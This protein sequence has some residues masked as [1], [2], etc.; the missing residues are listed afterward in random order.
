MQNK[1]SGLK[2]QGW[3]QAVYAISSTQKESLNV[4]RYLDDGRV[5]A[6]AQAGAG[7]LSAGLLTQ[8]AISSANALNQAL[9]ASQSAAI[10]DMSVTITFAG[11][12]TAD[13]YKDG[14]FFVNDATGEGHNYRIRGHAAGTADVVVYLYDPIRVALVASTSEWTCACNVQKLV[15]PCPV[16]L[17]GI[18]TGV[19]T[20]PVTAL[21]YFWNQVKGPCSV[22][23]NGTIVIGNEV[24]LHSTTIGSVGA[25]TTSDIIGS[26]GRVMLLNATTEYSLIMLNIPG[27]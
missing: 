10:G 26:V 14:W 7:A 20:V 15:I 9:S 4:V 27:Y 6:Y 22:L 8:T 13:F 12:V 23:T 19:P 21:Y 16:A 25:L 24:G 1:I 11:A 3:N 2:L 5:F 18:P 17:T